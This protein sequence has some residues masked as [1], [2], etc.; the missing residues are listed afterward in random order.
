MV[1]VLNRRSLSLFSFI[2][3]LI[4][5]LIFSRFFQLPRVHSRHFHAHLSIRTETE[6]TERGKEERQIQMAQSRNRL[7]RNSSSTLGNFHRSN[8]VLV[9]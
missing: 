6:R 1:I 7:S 4:L 2:F 3:I 5:I 8:F 9:I